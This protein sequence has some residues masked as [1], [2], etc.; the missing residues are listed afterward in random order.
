MTRRL[1][2]ED[3]NLLDFTAQVM[4]CQQCDAYW[5][6]CW[7]GRRFSRRAADRARITGHW[8]RPM[9]WTRTKRAASSSTG[10]TRP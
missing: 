10:W 1:F 6:V 3:V 4:D 9:Y 7:T 8:V 5:D 2:D